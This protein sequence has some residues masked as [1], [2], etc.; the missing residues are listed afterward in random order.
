M[1]EKEENLQLDLFSQSGK[2]QVKGLHEQERF[3]SFI[4]AYEKKIILIIGIAVTGII[5]F[6]IGV[7]KGKRIAPLKNTESTEDKAAVTAAVNT[8]QAKQFE[9]LPIVSVNTSPAQNTKKA[10]EYGAGYTIQLASYKTRAFA[11]KEAELLKKKGFSP[12]IISKG[13][14]TI[15][16]VGKFTDKETAQSLLAQLAKKYQGCHLRRL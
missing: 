7:E 4:R 1:M 9:P 12:Q 16:C 15:L 14:Y 11:Q 2:P 5:C 6:S 13:N 10:A 8:L 3:Y